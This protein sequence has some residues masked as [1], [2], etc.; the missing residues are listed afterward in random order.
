[1]SLMCEA[2]SIMRTRTAVGEE[3]IWRLDGCAPLRELGI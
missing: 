1:M 2:V 3:G